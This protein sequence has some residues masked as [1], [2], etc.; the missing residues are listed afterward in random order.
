MMLSLQEVEF[1]FVTDAA[2]SSET[3]CPYQQFLGF[4]L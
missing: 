3:K 1:S 2:G 4:L